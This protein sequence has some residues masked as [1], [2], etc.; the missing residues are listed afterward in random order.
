MKKIDHKEELKIVSFYQNGS[1]LRGLCKL[2]KKNLK[3]IKKCLLKHNVQFRTLSEANRIYSVDESIFENI[4]SHEKAYWL[5]F[6]AADGS[7]NGNRIKIGLSIKDK[8][9]I[10][11]FKNFLKSEHKIKEYHPFVKGKKYHSCEIM[12]T[13]TKIVEDLK[14]LN[15]TENKSSTLEIPKIN[16]EYYSSYL[17]GLFDGDGGFS[18]DKKLQMKSYLISSYNI[19]KFTIAILST[20]CNITETKITKEKRSEAMYYC[21]FGGNLKCKNI[22]NFLYKNS[23]IF[24]KRKRELINNHYLLLEQIK[25]EGKMLKDYFNS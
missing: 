15:I 1:S 7:I 2:Y 14:K 8:D 12:I 24:L 17:L 5:G 4:D 25:L 9:H 19:C 20:N 21:Y 3:F 18:V 10:I 6:L 22:I 16:E 11:L 23:T 13:S